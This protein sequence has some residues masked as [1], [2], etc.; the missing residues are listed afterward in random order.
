MKFVLLFLV[1]MT[2]IPGINQ[3]AFAM[4]YFAMMPITAMA[5]D[6]RCKWD[7]LAAMMP[8]SAKDIVLSK[9]LLG[10][11][12]MLGACLLSF[13]GNSIIKL[14]QHSSITMEEALSILLIACVGVILLAVNLPFI[15]RFGVE[16]G[17]LVFM[18]I[19]AGS[20]FALMMAGDQITTLLNANQIRPA[21]LAA[22]GVAA[23][24]MS[25]L[26]S[27]AISNAI[28]KKKVL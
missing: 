4:I 27:I 5:Y 19:I 7:S 17:R 2:A 12:G 11:I 21:L 26:I 23:A 1:I 14:F 9:Y 24:A 18:I 20:V 3:S 16:K 22:I 10:Y 25:N 28:Y 15:F 8:Y 13:G 6:E